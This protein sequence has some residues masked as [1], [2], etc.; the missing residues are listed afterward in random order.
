MNKIT[1]EYIYNLWYKKYIFSIKGFYPRQIKNF[2]KAKA[3]DKWSHIQK[4]CDLF[5]RNN[6]RI[7][8]EIF[9]NSQIHY[10]NSNIK[11]YANQKSIRRYILYKEHL[12][13]FDKDEDIYN[14]VISSIK[15]VS[16][17][18]VDNRIKSLK[19]YLRDDIE[20]YPTVIKHYESR[21]ISKYFLSL[22][23][24]LSI[25]IS[26]NSNEFC[27][28]TFNEGF[29]NELNNL[30]ILFNRSQKNRKITDNVEQIIDKLIKQIG[31]KQNE[32]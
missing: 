17:Y 32:Q 7:D 27:N 1:P 20:L 9:I 13:N 21:K 23:S 18:C 31:D 14:S 5:I 10:G 29:I 16:Q 24:K 22:L 12:D 25:F 6:G 3:S 11:T 19:A 28:E 26:G 4:L 30:Y 2:E 8:P 15:F